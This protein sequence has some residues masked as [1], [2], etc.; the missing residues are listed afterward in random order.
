MVRCTHSVDSGADI[1][2]LTSP[3]LD[4]E[5]CSNPG[6]VDAC[7]IVSTCWKSYQT[8]RA[9]GR[10]RPFRPGDSVLTLNEARRS[11]R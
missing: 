6:M 7:P 4:E 8:S 3:A 5:Q 2:P 11:I 10:R 1:H 9:C